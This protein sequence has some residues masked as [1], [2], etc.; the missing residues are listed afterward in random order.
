MKRIIFNFI[1]GC[2]KVESGHNL[3][4]YKGQINGLVDG[5]GGAT[6]NFVVEEYDK[7]TSVSLSADY[8]AFTYQ[9]PAIVL[10]SVPS[11]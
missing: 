4:V 7:K 9:S 8:L 2:K 10:G 6:H 11:V 3:I 5:G 1:Y